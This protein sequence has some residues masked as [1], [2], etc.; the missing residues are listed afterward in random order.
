[1][2]LFESELLL[3]GFDDEE[4]ELGVEVLLKMA[5][6]LFSGGGA[7]HGGGTRFRIFRCVPKLRVWL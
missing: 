5:A 4:D 2:K 3:E 1:M 7:G 6:L